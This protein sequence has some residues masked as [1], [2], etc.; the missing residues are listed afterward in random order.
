[1]SMWANWEQPEACIDSFDAA[2]VSQ[3]LRTSIGVV[4]GRLVSTG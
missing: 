2:A 4:D 3:A 1:M